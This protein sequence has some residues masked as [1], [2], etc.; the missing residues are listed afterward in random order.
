MYKL[1][2][3]LINILNKPIVNYLTPSSSPNML[4]RI[5]LRS[6]PGEVDYLN[7]LVFFEKLL[8]LRTLVPLSTIPEEEYPDI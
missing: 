1:I 4:R 8:P 3:S 6:I 2:R 7:I 5:L